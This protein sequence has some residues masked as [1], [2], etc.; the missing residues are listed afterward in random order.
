VIE[1]EILKETQGL[2]WAE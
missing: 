2:G 1:G